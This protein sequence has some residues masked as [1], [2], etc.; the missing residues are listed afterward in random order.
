MA[1]VT[2]S[3]VATATIETTTRTTE[4]IMAGMV[5]RSSHQQTRILDTIHDWRVHL[6][7][8]SAYVG[9]LS[10]LRCV[11]SCAGLGLSRSFHDLRCQYY[12]SAN[13]IGNVSLFQ[14]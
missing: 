10:F 2:E 14:K 13:R 3:F 11:Q 8:H 9:N 12:H 5:L 6:T 7:H 1:R 4:S